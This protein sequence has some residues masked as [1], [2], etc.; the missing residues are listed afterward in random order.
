MRTSS[1]LRLV[2]V[3]SLAGLLAACGGGSTTTLS[4]A[5]SSA[6][7]AAPSSTAPAAGPLDALTA[8]EIA[9]KIVTGLRQAKSVRI[10]GFVVDSG[11]KMTM[12]TASI[13]GKG[14]QGTIS[15]GT[16]GTFQVKTIGTSTWLSADRVFWGAQA[17]K[18]PTVAAVLAGKWIKLSAKSDLTSLTDLC[19]MKDAMVK[20]FGSDTKTALK[21]GAV[22]TLDGA[23]AL[24]LKDTDQ[25]TLYVSVD[26]A[27]H[28]LRVTSPSGEGDLT[29]S[30]YDT[31]PALVAPAAA[32]VL[33]GKKYG[34]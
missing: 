16:K 9:G 21:K 1:A 18:N 2:T 27:P 31:V 30:D 3:G 23:P 5:G 33:D 24:T 13:T 19:K 17:T 4:G 6:P 26:A 20:E 8:D 15:M 14:C 12:D 29:F 25:S 10:K 32:T 7:A 34:V 22:T 11:Q 28:L